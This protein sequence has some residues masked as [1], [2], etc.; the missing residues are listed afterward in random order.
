MEPDADALTWRTVAGFFLA[1]A[2]LAVV[3]APVALWVGPVHRALVLRVAGAVLAAGTLSR[4]VSALRNAVRLDMPSE[5]A[6]VL[7]RPL[8]PAIPDPGFSRLANELRGLPSRGHATE[9]LLWTRLR[10]TA[11]KRD[12][13][14]PEVAA[15]PGRR[16]GKADL[17]RLITAI[18][19]TR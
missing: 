3:A 17:D 10:A 6:R 15:R 5:V 13:A 18:E 12:I 19:Q 2:L 1:A 16:I 4:L 11:T 8:L 9:P 14:E 7:D